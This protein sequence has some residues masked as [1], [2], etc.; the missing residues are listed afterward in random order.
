M[1]RHCGSS[2][3]NHPT[4]H[5]V[6]W[7]RLP[8]HLPLLPRPL[9]CQWP[10]P[11]SSQKCVMCT[12]TGTLHC[13]TLGILPARNLSVCLLLLMARINS[14]LLSEYTAGHHLQ[15]P[16]ESQFRSWSILASLCFLS[17]CNILS[18][19]SLTSLSPTNLVESLLW[20]YVPLRCSQSPLCSPPWQTRQ[21]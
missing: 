20:G 4:S 7:I 15:F 12:L 10:H 11:L 16:L 13:P 8:E 3:L 9:S 2:S 1:S 21:K 5:L 18:H 17:A 6:L 19:F 14:P